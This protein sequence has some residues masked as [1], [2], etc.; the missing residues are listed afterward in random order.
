MSCAIHT[1]TPGRSAVRLHS[2][3]QKLANAQVERGLVRD[4]E[5]WAA[6]APYA[7]R[8][9]AG[10]TPE[11]VENT[12]DVPPH[13]RYAGAVSTPG[14]TPWMSGW[15][16]RPRSSRSCARR[17]LLPY[18]HDAERRASSLRVHRAIWFAT[19]RRAARESR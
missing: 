7:A 9:R 19:A 8:R 3:Y 2:R 17:R 5:P 4:V 12:A 11:R 16:M 14:H 6:I 13:D 1:A 18:G 10:I 15:P